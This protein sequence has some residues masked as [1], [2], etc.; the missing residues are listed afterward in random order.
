MAGR[1]EEESDVEFDG[2]ELDEDCLVG[3]AG[4]AQ[5]ERVLTR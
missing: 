2:M 1:E 4:L 5:A 3:M